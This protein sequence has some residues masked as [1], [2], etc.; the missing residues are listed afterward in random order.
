MFQQ[1]RIGALE[2]NLN[3]FMSY[4]VG[5]DK[6]LRPRHLLLLLND[7]S[8]KLKHRLSSSRIPAGFGHQATAGVGFEQIDQI[9]ALNVMQMAAKSLPYLCGHLDDINTYFQVC[10]LAC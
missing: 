1:I 5:S 4:S 3:F 2:M 8:E 6:H 9:P 7:F 10:F